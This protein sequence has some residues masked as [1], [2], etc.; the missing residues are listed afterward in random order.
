ML[1]SQ[2]ESSSSSQLNERAVV[3]IPLV[4]D[5]G[6]TVSDSEKL[7][8]IE[9]W[10]EPYFAVNQQGNVTVTLEEVQGKPIELLE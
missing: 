4:S 3:D 8:N 6:W 1:N 10:G 9:G 7:Y 2:S 5:A